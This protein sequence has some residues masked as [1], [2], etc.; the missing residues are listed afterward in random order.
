MKDDKNTSENLHNLELTAI[1]PYLLHEQES[2]QEEHNPSARGRRGST[3]GTG[4]SGKALFGF[5]SPR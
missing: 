1:N 5:R 3:S 4:R 2:E